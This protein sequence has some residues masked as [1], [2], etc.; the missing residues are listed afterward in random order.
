[1]GPGLE[2]Y[3]G[4][5]RVE[6]KNW[7]EKTLQFFYNNLRNFKLSVPSVPRFSLIYDESFKNPP[8]YSPSILPNFFSLHFFPPP[9]FSIS[10]SPP[11]S[12][13]SDFFFGTQIFP[14]GASC[15]GS[16]MWYGL[17]LKPIYYCRGSGPQLRFLQVFFKHA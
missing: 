3:M 7:S 14:F 17:H 1:M 5:N 10:N 6:K 15:Q 9:I 13:G 8:I 16:C 12:P 11:K 4:K 2:P